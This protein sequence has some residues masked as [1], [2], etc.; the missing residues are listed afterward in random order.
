MKPLSTKD[1]LLIIRLK[2]R[3]WLWVFSDVLL[4]NVV[5]NLAG[6]IL[7]SSSSLL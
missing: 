2:W 4:D 5:I 6:F 3:A 1:V 7:A